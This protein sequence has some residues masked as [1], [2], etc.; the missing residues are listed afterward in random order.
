MNPSMD[1]MDFACSAD[2]LAANPVDNVGVEFGS[3]GGIEDPRR[4]W[5]ICGVGKHC[6][7]RNMKLIITVLPQTMVPAP[8][9][10]AASMSSKLAIPT[11][12]G[13]VAALF[14]SLLLL[15]V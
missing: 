7:S 2:I 1:S 13:F 14:G 9:P 15:F 8:S 4:K 10:M 11:F 6:E 12:Y 3:G 5:Y